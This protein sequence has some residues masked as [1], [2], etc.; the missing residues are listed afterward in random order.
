[1]TAGEL[2]WAPGYTQGELDGAQERFD[3]RFPPDLVDLL[4]E[5]R[6]PRGWDWTQD[7]EQIRIM[8]GRPLD[9]I[10]FDV[11]NNGLWWPEWG[12]R[13][14]GTAARAEIVAD[15]I[16]D[17]PKLIPLFSHRFIP[18]EPH[19]PGNPVFSVYQ[20]D[21]IYYGSN[22]Q[23]YI[24]NEFSVPHRYRIGPEIRRIRFWSDAVDRA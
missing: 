2:V 17:A 15:V 18:E 12:D 19:A 1:M 16:A 20:S 22:L 10:L 6:F 4:R 21:I 24:E 5:R 8:L 3:L 14:Q 11:E 23:N 13:P 7:D 9:G